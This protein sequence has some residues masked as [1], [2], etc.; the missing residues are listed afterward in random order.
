MLRRILNFACLT[1][2]LLAFAGTARAQGCIMCYESASAASL[3]V[4]HA[5]SA[6]V[7]VLL[8]PVALLLTTMGL[9][10]WRSARFYSARYSEFPANS[11]D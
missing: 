3:T 2:G 6:G 7:L 9:M 8:V 1:A 11:G 10:V 4:R 5:L